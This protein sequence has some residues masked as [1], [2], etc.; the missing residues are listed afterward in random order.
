MDAPCTEPVWLAGGDDAI[1]PA[2]TYRLS[3]RLGGAQRVEAFRMDRVPVTIE[4]YARFIDAGGYDE[5]DYWD[6]D[7]WQWK[8]EQRIDVPRFW[9]EPAWRRFIRR[10][11]PVVGVSYWEVIAFCRFEGRRLPTER[12]WEAAARGPEGRLYTWGDAWEDGRLGIRGIGPRVTWP[13]GQFRRARG[14]FGHDDLLGNVW[15][16]T[17]D[18]AEVHDPDR[19]RIV[20]GGS[21]ASRADQNDTVMWNAYVLGARFSHL[22]FRTVALTTERSAKR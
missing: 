10:G 13:V 19:A 5:P 1:V 16:W 18:P 6:D 4:R 17:S 22:G 2:G 21:W 3:D 9:D 7:A 12:E 20:R 8:H 14:P 15:Q 11:R